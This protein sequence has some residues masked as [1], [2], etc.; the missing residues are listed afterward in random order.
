MR[1]LGQSRS[2]EYLNGRREGIKW[3]IAWLH[4][5]AGEMND[6]RAKMILNV[7]ATDIGAEFSAMKRAD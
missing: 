2:D 6:P 4:H 7:V 5:K 3:C 1:R